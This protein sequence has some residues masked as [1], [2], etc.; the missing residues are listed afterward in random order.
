MGF[1]VIEGVVKYIIIPEIFQS[2]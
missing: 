2:M 1:S